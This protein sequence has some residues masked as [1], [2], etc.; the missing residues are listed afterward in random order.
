MIKGS[1]AQ[2]HRFLVTCGTLNSR[3]KDEALCRASWRY[4]ALDRVARTR[5]TKANTVSTAL[6]NRI[7]ALIAKI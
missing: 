5:L 3:V 4:S 7:H 6:I 1:A 2:A